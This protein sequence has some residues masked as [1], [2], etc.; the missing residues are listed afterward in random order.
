MRKLAYLLGVLAMGWV[1][2]RRRYT[3]DLLHVYQVNMLTLPA[4]FV[5]ALVSKPLIVAPR[6]ADS[7]HPAGAGGLSRIPARQLHQS[8]QQ[9]APHE[10]HD[11][12]TGD[13][14]AL[15]QLGKPV[16]CV[17]RYL[18]RR[19]GA[20]MVVLSSRM[21]ADLTAH[22]FHWS[23]VWVIPNGVDVECFRPRSGEGARAGRVRTV[24]FVGRLAY[25][26]GVDVLLR[27]WRIVQEQLPGYEQTRLAIVGA[28]PRQAQL[29]QLARTLDIADNVEF[30]GLQRDVATWL[31]Q[32]DL[33]VI[34]SR[35]E[36]MPNAL[37]EAMACGV[38]C[39][40]T[41]VSGSEDLI[42]NGYNGLLVEPE[43]H[44]GMAQALLSL[45]RDPALRLQ[46]SRAARDTVEER[47][48]LERVIAAYL[49]LY[50]NLC[51]LA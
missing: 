12:T 10:R 16:V 51:C 38:A 22:G 50:H 1:L 18:L 45:L 34:P 44:E 46:Y 3:Y 23:R 33:A 2:W 39:V 17:T 27:A 48:T 13:L 20:V 6:C 29:E 41:R 49:D 14:E 30:L 47:Y 24:M 9:T 5:C 25:Q 15:E 36:G 7:G 4:A 43:D 11:R 26:K 42:Q 8:V 21:K 19:A 32:G 40:A 28:G 35:W 37:L 31:G